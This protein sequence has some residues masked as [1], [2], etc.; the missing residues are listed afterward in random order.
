MFCI[1]N[2]FQVLHLRS[3]IAI[4]DCVIFLPFMGLHPFS[5][6]EFIYRAMNRFRTDVVGFAAILYC[7]RILSELGN[8]SKFISGCKDYLFAPTVIGCKE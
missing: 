3:A 2:N 8:C 5:S 6:L 4:W 1:K 7:S